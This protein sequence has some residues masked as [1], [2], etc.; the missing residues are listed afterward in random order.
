[1][2]RSMANGMALLPG[3]LTAAWVVV[4]CAAWLLHLWHARSM[5]GGPRWWHAG[6]M[7]M[8][9]GMI[10]MYV[11][12]QAHHPRLYW[13]GVCVFAALGAG[14]GTLAAA[15]WRR[16]GRPD[17]LWTAATADMAAM[18]Y[19]S[20]PAA[21]RAALPSYLLVTYLCVEALLWALV[22]SPSPRMRA[23]GHDRAASPSPGVR[24]TLAVMSV[25]MAW[26]LVVMQSMHMTTG[27]PAAPM[28]M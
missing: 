6:H 15:A 20:L 16:T 13:A 5:R 1:M 27:V 9:A 7:V 28:H 25:S 2:V 22:P 23:A 17:W 24:A 12:P 8:A 4:L 26:M 18:T 10:A 21:D 11:L 19:M 14:S 3:W